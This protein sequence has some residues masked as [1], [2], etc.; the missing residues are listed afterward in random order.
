MRA[1]LS[2]EDLDPQSLVARVRESEPI[3]ARNLVAD[4]STKERYEVAGEGKPLAGGDAPSEDGGRPRAHVVALDCGEKRGIVERLAAAGCDVTVAP[5]DTP[6]ADV[7]ALGPD[8][9]FLSNGPDRKS[10]RLNSS[11]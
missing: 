2:T 9:V 7:L 4:V 8:G 6:A 10:T 1:A 5:W 11:H 3:S